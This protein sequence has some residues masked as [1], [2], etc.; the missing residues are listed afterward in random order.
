MINPFALQERRY[1]ITG[2]ASGIGRATAEILSGMG[3]DLILVDI[4]ERGLEETAKQCPAATTTLRI[5]LSDTDSL[6]PAIE[7]AVK[8]RGKLNGIVHVAGLPYISPIKALSIEKLNAV[9]AVNTYAAAIIA[10]IFSNRKIYAGVNGSI[11]FVSSV[12]A[13]VGSPC[14]AGYAMS[15]AAIEGLTRALT[16][17]LAGRKIRVNCVAPGFIKTPMDTAVSV[18][19]DEAH[20]DVISGLHPLGLG[21]PCDIAYAIAYLLSDAAKWVT[22]SI[23]HVDVGFTAQ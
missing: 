6:T 19:F 17:E 13:S 9:F 11:V 4:N 2:A 23:L 12:Y 5:D 14:N 8:E 1:L 7:A 16:M 21:E 10:K 22:G 15:K 18:Y 3:A 20:G